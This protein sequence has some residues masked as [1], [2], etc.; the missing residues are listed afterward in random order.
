MKGRF[1]ITILFLEL[2]PD[3][4]DVN[5]HP[6]KAEVRFEDKG[7]IFKAVSRGVRR[8]LMAHTPVQ[9]VDFRGVNLWARSASVEPKTGSG[10]DPAWNALDAAREM[11]QLDGIPADGQ[12]P[13]PLGAPILRLIGQVAATY[14]VAEGPDG[15]Y[16]IDQHAAHERV[17]FEKYSL[18][19]GEDHLSQALLDSVVVDFSP[20]SADLIKEHLDVLK[21]LGFEM[22][23]F[24]P[25]SF[26][27][28]AIPAEFQNA[29]PESL[30]R[31]AVEDLEVDE[32]PLDKN[33][34]D[35]IIARVCKRA[36]VK[37]GQVLTPEEQKKLLLDLEAC[38]SPRTCPHG[39]PTMI[40]LSVDFFERRFGRTG[41][42]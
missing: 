33:L 26:V 22:E 18:N 4:V 42:I 5:V 14:L 17:L 21:G 27:I 32:T 3:R 13:A 10:I 30:L 8:A 2:A 36:A 37:A 28:R 24:G 20:T 16:L 23:E 11:A 15:L 7:N 40:H 6:A 39:R 9:E 31:S 12:I 34:E 38:Q 29:S 19:K 1:P 41:S 25:G 35:Q